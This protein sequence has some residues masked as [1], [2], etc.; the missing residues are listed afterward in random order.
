MALSEISGLILHS[1]A[2]AQVLE[3]RSGNPISMALLY[4]EVAQRCKFPMIGLN[5]PAHFML[6]PLVRG[7]L[8]LSPLAHGGRWNMAGVYTIEG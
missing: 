3:N 7:R 8:H 5:M 4:L 6:T 2:G 1:V